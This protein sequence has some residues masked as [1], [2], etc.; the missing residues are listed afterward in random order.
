MKAERRRKERRKYVSKAKKQERK[1]PE[2]R[3]GEKNFNC[4]R[5]VKRQLHPHTSIPLMLCTS[6]TMQIVPA[7]KTPL[8]TL[9]N[10]P[11]RCCGVIWLELLR[12][13]EG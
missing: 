13:F 10:S 5:Q 6:L 1:I 3:T 4:I 7:M 11:R 2:K 12:D 9:T 8:S